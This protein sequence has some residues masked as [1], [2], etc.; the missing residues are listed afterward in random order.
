[1]EISAN[2]Y[3]PLNDRVLRFKK[4]ESII[5]CGKDIAAPHGLEP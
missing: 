2:H 5:G 1:M 4:K 3:I